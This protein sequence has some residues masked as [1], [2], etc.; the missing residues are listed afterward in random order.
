MILMFTPL[1]TIVPEIFRLL[2]VLELSLLC[3]IYYHNSQSS[4]ATMRLSIDHL[5]DSLGEV[6]DEQFGLMVLDLTVL[7][8]SSSE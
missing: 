7:H 1:H 6:R 5:L 3:T 2:Q 4:A 8:R